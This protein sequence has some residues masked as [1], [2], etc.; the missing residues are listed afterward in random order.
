MYSGAG[1]TMRTIGQNP[2]ESGF[3]ADLA[4]GWSWDFAQLAEG[5]LD[6]ER[7]AAPLD[8]GCIGSVTVDR[9]CL[10]QVHAFTGW[11]LA[12]VPA[13]ESG[14]VYIEGRR[15]I[16]GDAVLLPPGSSLELLSHGVGRLFLIAV[17]ADRTGAR[18]RLRSPR[19][20]SRTESRAGCLSDD[21]RAWLEASGS[22][23]FDSQRCHATRARLLLWLQS[24]T[25][26]S[27]RVEGEG[28]ALSRRRVA[29]ERVRRFIHDHLAETMTL[30]ELCQHA[31]LQARSLEYGFRDLVG[32]SPFKYIKMLRLAEVRRRLQTSSPLERSVSELALDCGFCHLSQFAADYKRVFLESPSA[33]RRVAERPGSTHVPRYEVGEISIAAR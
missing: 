7:Q 23:G 21:L 5:L 24:I 9:A 10:H 25:A 26:D 31:H 15:L 11:F 8:D 12:L 29:V 13:P 30:A 19:W 32:L 33:T 2:V 17:P 1:D 28:P 6:V 20:F 3:P 18:T 14:A 16:A 4:T 27:Q 22:T